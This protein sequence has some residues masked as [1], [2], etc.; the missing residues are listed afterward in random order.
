MGIRLNLAQLAVL[1]RG[2]L[3]RRGSA[4]RRAFFGETLDD[5]TIQTELL[6][7]LTD[8]LR[9]LA[10]SLGGQKGLRPPPTKRPYETA[11]TTHALGFDPIPIKDF[12]DWW[13]SN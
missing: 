1:T 13:E 10:W 12:E 7:C 11:D 8:Q 2:F 6:A 4:L 9:T 3:H 5:W